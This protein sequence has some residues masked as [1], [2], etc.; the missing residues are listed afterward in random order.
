M[1]LKPKDGDFVSNDRN[2]RIL[3]AGELKSA[4]IWEDDWGFLVSGKA[5]DY[6]TVD[7]KIQ[8][9]ENKLTQVKDCGFRTSATVI[10]KG[11]NLEM[12]QPK[13]YNILKNPD[14]RPC[15]RKPKKMRK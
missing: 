2:W 3:I 6:E 4:Q 11:S 9:L 8:K 5:A 15:D 12:F 14:L 13:E 10:G 1:S 7:S